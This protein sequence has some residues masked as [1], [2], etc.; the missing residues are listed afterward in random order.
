MLFEPIYDYQAMK[1]KM[2]DF[3]RELTEYVFHPV[4]LVRLCNIYSL[5]L[6]EYI[7]IINP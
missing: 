5:D 3:C 7:V 6:E 4:R 2:Q 1:N